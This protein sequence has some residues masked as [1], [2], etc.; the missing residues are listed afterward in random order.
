[1]IGFV[2]TSKEWLNL[3]LGLLEDF[4]CYLQHVVRFQGVR[5][6]RNVED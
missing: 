5:V 6:V 1:M 2:Y 4:A 3:G